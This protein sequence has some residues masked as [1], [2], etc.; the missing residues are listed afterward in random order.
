M[1]C[2]QVQAFR[3]LLLHVLY[4][5]RLKPACRCLPVIQSQL[6]VCLLEFTEEH[7]KPQ[8]SQIFCLSAFHVSPQVICVNIWVLII[9]GHLTTL[10]G[11]FFG[12]WESNLQAMKGWKITW[13]YLSNYFS[14]WHG[15]STAGCSSAGLSQ[16]IPLDFLQFNVRKYGKYGSVKLHQP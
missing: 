3:S 6:L 2:S 10:F 12:P 1:S 8:H 13:V 11:V 9:T 14:N 15:C 5:A 7:W 16:Q 4:L